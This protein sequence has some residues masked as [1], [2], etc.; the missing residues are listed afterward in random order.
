MWHYEYTIEGAPT[1][2]GAETFEACLTALIRIRARQPNLTD[3]GIFEGGTVELGSG[4]DCLTRAN[5]W[6]EPRN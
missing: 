2:H 3:I 5:P 6:P 1:R 4:V